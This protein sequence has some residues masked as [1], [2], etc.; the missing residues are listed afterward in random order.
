MIYK[1]LT[2]LTLAFVTELYKCNQTSELV[3]HNLNH[4]KNVLDRTGE[5][6]SNYPLSDKDKFLVTA[7]AGFHDC[8]HMYGPA[9]DHETSSA[10]IMRDYFKNKIPDEDIEVIAQCILA[11]RLPNDPHSL[12]EE[13]IC[14]ADSYHLGTDRFPYTNELVRKEFEWRNGFLPPDWD[15]R[16]LHLLENHVYFTPYCKQLL[17]EGKKRNIRLVKEMIG[18]R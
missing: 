11:T 7:A 2:S 10:L 3:Y 14:D 12:L 5:I 17:N 15:D 9:L 13:I 4:T 1:R 8:G 18:A 16:T 6:A